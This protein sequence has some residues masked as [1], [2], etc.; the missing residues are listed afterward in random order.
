M[1]LTIIYISMSEASISAG[2]LM[3]TLMNI[4]SLLHVMVGYDRLARVSLWEQLGV[5]NLATANYIKRQPDHRKILETHEL[6]TLNHLIVYYKSRY[7]VI[8]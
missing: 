5:R 8:W 7:E 4:V 3:L 1:P 2:D 6:S